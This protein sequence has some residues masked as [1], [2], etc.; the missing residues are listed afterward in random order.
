M[1]NVAPAH[2]QSLADTVREITEPKPQDDES[3]S[4]MQPYALLAQDGTEPTEPSEPEELSDPGVPEEPTEPSEP[5]EPKEPKEPEKKECER[6][7]L[8]L[9]VDGN[10]LDAATNRFDEAN[11]RVEELASQLDLVRE[12]KGEAVRKTRGAYIG[13]FT[14][15]GLRGAAGL[16]EPLVDYGGKEIDF[17]ALAEMHRNAVAERDLRLQD[18]EEAEAEFSNTLD[19]LAE[20]GCD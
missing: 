7:R 10:N 5:K 8:Q 18:V 20:N 1:Q 16:V 11:K 15:P 19:K 6:L 9:E 4:D 17:K 2:R 12:G 3:V 14:K 13:F